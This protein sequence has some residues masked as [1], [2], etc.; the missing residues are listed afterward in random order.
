LATIDKKGPKIGGCAARFSQGGVIL[1]PRRARMSDSLLSQVAFLK[2]NKSLIGYWTSGA[3]STSVY[4]LKIMG[5]Q[6]LFL[7][8]GNKNNLYFV[9]CNPVPIIYTVGPTG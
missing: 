9:F 5:I 8:G 7:K 3:A 6:T 2:C 1:T 4:V